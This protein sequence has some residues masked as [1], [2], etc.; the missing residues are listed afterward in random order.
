MLILLLSGINRFSSDV[1]AMLG[2]APGLFWRV[3]WVAISPAFLAVRA[4]PFIHFIQWY[5]NSKEYIQ[6]SRTC[7]FQFYNILTWRALKRS[8]KRHIFKSSGDQWSSVWDQKTSGARSANSWP[9]LCTFNPPLYELSSMKLFLQHVS[10]INTWA[11]VS[12]P[13]LHTV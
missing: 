5:L 6:I 9:S 12:S 8:N 3:C 4:Q 11:N 7:D 13:P 1:Q 10:C 2:K